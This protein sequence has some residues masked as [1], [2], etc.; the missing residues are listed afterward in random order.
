MSFA[1]C[2][3][4]TLDVD[5]KGSEI[6]CL[7]KIEG[8]FQRCL[9]RRNTAYQ[10]LGLSSHFSWPLNITLFKNYSFEITLWEVIMSLIIW[11]SLTF[12]HY[13]YKVNTKDKPSYRGSA[14]QR[15]WS[16]AGVP[17]RHPDE[18]ES[19]SALKCE[20]KSSKNEKVFFA[21]KLCPVNILIHLLVT[22]LL[23]HCCV[24]LYTI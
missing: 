9:Q 5:T 17:K 6:N 18:N 3:S 16:L 10:K 23:G 4:Y 21:Q 12:F 20:E 1:L 11:Y 2:S 24:Y 19:K 13:Y 7:V 15:A 22:G 14:Y 8:S